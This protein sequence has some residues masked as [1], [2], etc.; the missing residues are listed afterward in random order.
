MVSGG[1]P[2]RVVA[3]LCL[4]ACLGPGI[5]RG[6]GNPTTG[7]PMARA[8]ASQTAVGNGTLPAVPLGSDIRAAN[9]DDA[10][11]TFCFGGLVHECK[12]AA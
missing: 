2:E 6:L 5:T 11:A 7:R 9:G 10:H 3:S 8:D 1:D 4:T 12:L